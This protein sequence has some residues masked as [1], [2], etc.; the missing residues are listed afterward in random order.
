LPA[1]T[2]ITARHAVS[3]NPLRRHQHGNRNADRCREKTRL[4][5]NDV[6][7]GH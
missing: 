3:S 1:S 4:P 6:L 2:S 7:A 5:A